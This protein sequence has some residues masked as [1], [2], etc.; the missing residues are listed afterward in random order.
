MKDNLEAK[1]NHT[2]VEEG[3]YSHWIE[4]GYFTAGDLSI[5]R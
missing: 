2:E 4:E 1:Y 5:C 3:K